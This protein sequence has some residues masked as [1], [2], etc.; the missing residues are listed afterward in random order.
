LN[1]QERHGPARQAGDEHQQ[2]FAKIAGQQKL[3]Y[4]ADIVEDA[5]PFLDGADN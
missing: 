3:Q 1:R 2:D 4:L 5:A